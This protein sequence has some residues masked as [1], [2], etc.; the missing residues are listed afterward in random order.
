MSGA[1][2]VERE[3]VVH[4]RRVRVL[5]CDG[6]GPP[7]VLLH[8][9]GLSAGSWRPHLPLLAAA[10]FRVLA[11]DLPGFGRSA[12]PLAGY[13]IPDTAAWLDRFAE[14]EGLP[15]AA[16]VGHSLSAQSLLRLAR[17][18]PERVTALIL[19]APTGD[20]R[21]LRRAGA[22]LIGLAT[23]ALRERPRVVAGVLRRYLGAPLATF[24]AWLASRNH[25]PEADAAA[26]L[27][28]VLIVLGEEDPVVDA[29]F[30]HRLARR[31]RDV[32]L[33]VIRDAGHAVALDPAKEF[34]DLA[35]GF[36]RGTGL[37]RGPPARTS[38]SCCRRWSGPRPGSRPRG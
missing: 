36:L 30:A 26:T 22:Q 13:S 12:P 32:R 2:I 20:S 11:P 23:N 18:R 35:A 16:W 31:L 10:G 34:C 28:P 27:A 5:E 37:R 25:R 17:D 29:R 4:G 1:R 21:G 3:R 9:L 19:A 38:R 8:G 15:T 14:A 7:V 33:H 24:R 6:G